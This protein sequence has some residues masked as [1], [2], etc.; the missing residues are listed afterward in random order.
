M[1]SWAGLENVEERPSNA[2]SGPLV[3]IGP[4]TV[5]YS[6]DKTFS[7]L[8][9]V[10]SPYTKGSFYNSVR[11]PPVADNSFSTTVPAEHKAIRGKLA[12]GVSEGPLPPDGNQM[13]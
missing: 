8:T 5:L 1:S 12:G 3:R 9:G 10:R 7:R 6:D 13:K 11:I 4:N 2:G